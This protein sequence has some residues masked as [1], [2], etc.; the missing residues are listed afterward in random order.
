VLPERRLVI[1]VVGSGDDRER[2]VYRLVLP[3]LRIG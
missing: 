1:V 2:V 3:A